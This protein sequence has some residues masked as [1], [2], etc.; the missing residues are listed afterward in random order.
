MRIV[1]LDTPALVIDR[2]RLEANIHFMQAFADKSGVLLRP[3]AKTH[4]SPFIAALQLAAGAAGITVAKTAEAEVMAQN[5]IDD[6]FIA[7][8]IIGQQ[9]LARARALASRIRLSFGVDSVEGVEA[10]EAAFAGAPGPA[11]VLVEIEVGENRTGVSEEDAFVFLL[12][13]LGRCRHVRFC[14]VFSHEGHAYAAASLAECASFMRAAQEK[15]LR[16]AA[17]AAEMG[18]PCETVSTGSTPTLMNRLDILPGITEIRPGT[19]VLMDASQGNA[20]GTLERCAATVLAT[21][22]SRPTPER[23]VVDVGAKGLTMQRRERGICATPGLGTVMGWPGVYLEEV[24]DEHGIILHSGFREHVRV[25]DR[26]RIIPVH[27]CPVCNLYESAFFVQGEDVLGEV[28]ISA[29]GR[30]A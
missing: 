26:I 8:E 28:P 22:I 10:A 25:G 24:Y 20:I 3:H 6:I 14:G 5:G 18:M 1:E 15:T 4:K 23:V 12:R 7:N 16:F 2:Q 27:I 19:Y 30:M 17:L 21:I 29:R 13:R 9:K 11:R